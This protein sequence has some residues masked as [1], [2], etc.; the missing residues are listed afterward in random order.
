MIIMLLLL[1]IIGL[2]NKV[3]WQGLEV[4]AKLWLLDFYL[5]QIEQSPVE[6]PRDISKAPGS[7]HWALVIVI[8]LFIYLCIC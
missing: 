4:V 3:Y 6:E 7:Y 2:H 5:L 8:Y 1:V